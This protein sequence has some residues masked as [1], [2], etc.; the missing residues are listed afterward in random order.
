MVWKKNKNRPQTIP[1]AL[2]KNKVLAN[3]TVSL[4]TDWTGALAIHSWLAGVVAILIISTLV[5]NNTHF[6][7]SCRVR[8]TVIANLGIM[9]QTHPQFTLAIVFFPS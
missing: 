6:R 8:I 7:A 1:A 4:K 9:S 3:K 2:P 5:P